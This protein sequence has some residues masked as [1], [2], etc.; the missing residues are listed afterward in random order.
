M[1]LL[2]YIFKYYSW[3]IWEKLQSFRDRMKGYKHYRDLICITLCRVFKQLTV[4]TRLVLE[5]SFS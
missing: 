3:N 4:M 5:E 1:L 2:N